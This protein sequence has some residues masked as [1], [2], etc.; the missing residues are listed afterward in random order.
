MILFLCRIIVR[1]ISNLKIS[2]H[3]RNFI[4]LCIER[5]CFISL[6]Y[7]KPDLQSKRS[8]RF[9]SYRFWRLAREVHFSSISELMITVWCECHHFWMLSVV[10]VFSCECCQLW[11]LLWMSSCDSSLIMQAI[12][13]C[14]TIVLD[15][16]ISNHSRDIARDYQLSLQKTQHYQASMTIV[17]S[18]RLL[19]EKLRMI[20]SKIY[21]VVEH[22][23]KY[24]TYKSTKELNWS[25][26]ERELVSTSD[27]RSDHYWRWQ[28]T[29][30]HQCHR[31]SADFY[32]SR[33]QKTQR[34]R[35]V[36][37]AE[38]TEDRALADRRILI[39]AQNKSLLRRELKDIKFPVI[40][41][42]NYIIG[43]QRRSW[44]KSER[45]W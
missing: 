25:S 37:Q 2:H 9:E 5:F 22:H 26:L 29:H 15:Y 11:M 21:I 17:K 7:V 42:L 3:I 6:A 31:R 16:L 27:S 44:M 39:T 24:H 32:D 13:K 8:S 30:D 12:S 4:R 35:K 38:H 19:R 36:N 20:N 45:R 14:L 34:M 18:E 33:S 1:R 40:M 43:L 23:D 10:N 28:R 41:W